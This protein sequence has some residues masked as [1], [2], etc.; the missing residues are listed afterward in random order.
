MSLQDD[1]T[2]AQRCLDELVRSVGRVEEHLGAGLDIRRVRTDTDH[3]RDS[4]ALLRAAAPAPA[5]PA[6]PEVIRIPDQPYD[7]S[8][9][10]DVD[11]EGLGARDRR[12]P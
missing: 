12:A 9:W 8:L 5:A 1:L 2:A 10:S 3:L 7:R 6:R 11:D 4:L